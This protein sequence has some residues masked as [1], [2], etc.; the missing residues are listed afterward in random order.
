MR[1]LIPIRYLGF[2]DVPRNFLVRHEGEL[3]LFDCPFNEADDDYSASY[4]VYLL[5]EL[6]PAEIES[7]WSALPGKAIRK[8]GD[9]AVADVRF[10]PTRRKA[11]GV[12]VF[13]TIA[14]IASANGEQTN[15]KPRSRVS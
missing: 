13:D 1:E 10:D 15:A 12:E 8:V 2:W 6:S 4:A 9:V 14:P 11:V 3:Y 5:P 7:D